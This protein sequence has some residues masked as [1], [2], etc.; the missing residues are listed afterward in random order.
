MS[1][2]SPNGSTC[3]VNGQIRLTDGFSEGLAD[4]KHT[5]RGVWSLLATV[6]YLVTQSEGGRSATLACP[7]IVRATRSDY[8]NT[9]A[10]PVITESNGCGS[11]ATYSTSASRSMPQYALAVAS[12]NTPK[13]SPPSARKLFA[14]TV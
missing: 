9:F 6:R 13:L 3:T 10:R 8:G 14:V 7:A 12:L 1:Q 4:S 5:L 2:L 11:C